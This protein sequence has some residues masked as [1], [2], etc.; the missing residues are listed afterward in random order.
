MSTFRTVLLSTF[1]VGPFSFTACTA[2][3]PMDLVVGNIQ[4]ETPPNIPSIE[5]V[6]PNVVNPSD[7]SPSTSPEPKTTESTIP[8]LNELCAQQLHF[9]LPETGDFF[10]QN[11]LLTAVLH[12]PNLINPLD[13]SLLWEDDTGIILS[14]STFDEYGL[15]H[16]VDTEF[17]QANGAALLHARLHTPEG[18][19]PETIIKPVTVCS[20]HLFEDFEQASDIW[21]TSG[22]ATLHPEG[23]IELTQ[24]EQG[25]QGAYYNT[26]TWIQPGDMS[27]RMTIQTGNG[28][29]GGADGLALTFLDLENPEHLPSLIENA[30]P[31]GGIGY[32]IAEGSEQWSGEA[33]TVEIDTFENTGDYEHTDPTSSDHIGITERTNPEDHLAWVDTPDIADFETHN[34]RVD[35][36]QDNIHIY[37]D[38][39]LIL[40]QQ[41]HVQ[42]QG[43][44]VFLSGSTGWAT[45][46]HIVH[47]LEVFHGC[48][49]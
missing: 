20:K 26:E 6:T 12:A 31:G 49:D 36:I 11:D 47:D 29:H 16:F 28:I 8:S 22:D 41:T 30:L 48:N 7:S 39:T 2:G 14:E 34:I 9:V 42:F 5:E 45:N 1:V 27:I 18:M 32:A 21:S 19:C 23:W 46:Q 15:T 44:Y 37:L 25:R 24:N 17:T 38:D 43:G 40:K 4:S 33:L 10:R 35:I 13:Y 3:T